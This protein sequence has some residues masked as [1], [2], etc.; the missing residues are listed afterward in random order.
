[1]H[2]HVCML[3]WP[4]YCFAS[5]C[6][7][8]LWLEQSEIRTVKE[9]EITIV[10][11]EAVSCWVCVL[12]LER[13]W[14]CSSSVGMTVMGKPK[15]QR[16]P[17]P[18]PLCP[19]EIPFWLACYQTQVSNLWTLWALEFLT[20]PILT[21]NLWAMDLSMTFWPSPPPPPPS[22]SWGLLWFHLFLIPLKLSRHSVLVNARGGILS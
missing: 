16:K 5:E 21:L 2:E 14:I 17:V 9:R 20:C 19:P 15:C 6:V 22:S 3:I 13:E 10:C 1:M 7:L 4:L 11:N 8:V 18:V 12:L